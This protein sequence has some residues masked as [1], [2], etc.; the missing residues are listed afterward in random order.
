MKK[1]ISLI[2][3]LIVCISLTLVGAAVEKTNY[4]IAADAMVE[5]NIMSGYPDGTFG[6]D[7]NITRA[8]LVTSICRMLKLD[9]DAKKAKGKTGFNDVAAD[10]WSSGYIN[11][12]AKKKIIQG[13]GTGKFRPSDLVKYEEAIKMI[14]CATGYGDVAKNRGGYPSGYINVAKEQHIT[15]NV[16]V[17]LGEHATR[18]DVAI[19]IY[20]AINKEVEDVKV[21]K[22]DGTGVTGKVYYNDLFVDKAKVTLYRDGNHIP[23]H[24]IK[25]DNAGRYTFEVSPGNY[26]VVAKTSIAIA[27]QT[28]ISVSGDK[29]I[30]ASMKLQNGQNIEGK[31]LCKDAETIRNVKVYIKSDTFYI[32]NT[33]YRGTFKTIL[34]KNKSYEVFV[35]V[36]GALKSAGTFDLSSADEKINIG[37][38]K[39]D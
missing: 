30:E 27:S 28:N 18:G 8:E 13:D 14:V 36:D 39:L 11:I 24:E 12:A 20:Q 22:I 3:I 23:V 19:M 25:S 16:P 10:H 38:F 17:K 33:N 15:N 31:L 4:D 35:V 7:K 26:S 29:M 37:E 1:C 9:A 2:T 21:S 32:V 34:E 5:L 6:V